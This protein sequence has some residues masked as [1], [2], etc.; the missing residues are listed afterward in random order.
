MS[1]VIRCGSNVKVSIASSG[2]GARI[3]GQRKTGLFSLGG[4]CSLALRSL[5]LVNGRADR[6]GV[7]YADNAGDVEIIDSTV[8]GC[9]ADGAGVFNGVCRVA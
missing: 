2:E 9:S 5:A 1:S 6:G 3:D 4:G 8:K 7:V